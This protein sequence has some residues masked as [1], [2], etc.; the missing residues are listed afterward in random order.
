MDKVNTITF[1]LKEGSVECKEVC[2][3]I[4]DTNNCFKANV[5]LT[6][7]QEMYKEGIEKIGDE[8]ICVTKMV[9]FE[10]MTINYFAF[11][12]IFEATIE[13]DYFYIDTYFGNEAM[14]I[15]GISIFIDDTMNNIEV[16]KIHK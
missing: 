12:G 8:E 7:M 13:R 1:N 9:D 5:V 11:G 6:G 3:E 2:T 4:Y 15:V 16:K 14:D 10:S